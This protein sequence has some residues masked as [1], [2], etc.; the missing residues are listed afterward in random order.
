[1]KKQK[2]SESWERERKEKKYLKEYSYMIALA[3]LCSAKIRSRYDKK[4]E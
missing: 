1:M 3:N 4:L 2:Q